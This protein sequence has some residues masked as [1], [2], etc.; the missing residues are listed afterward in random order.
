MSIDGTGHDHPGD[1][2]LACPPVEAAAAV[3]LH[4]DDSLPAMPAGTGLF[5]ASLPVPAPNLRWCP[6]TERAQL[7]GL[8]EPS[9][10][11]QGPPPRFSAR[12]R[13]AQAGQEEAE[14]V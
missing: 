3:Q 5:A 11:L 12:G 2:P 7:R 14:A 13:L 6:A 8:P 4:Q 10:G 9:K 1:A